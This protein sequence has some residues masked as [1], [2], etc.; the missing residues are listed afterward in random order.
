MRAM[1][2][3]PLRKAMCRSYGNALFYERVRD[4]LRCRRARRLDAA[5]ETVEQVLNIIVPRQ[6]ASMMARLCYARSAQCCARKEMRSSMPLCAKECSSAQMRYARVRRAKDDALMRAAAYDIRQAPYA[7]RRGRSFDIDRGFRYCRRARRFSATI[8]GFSRY[9]AMPIRA[10]FQ[11]MRATPC[12]AAL[13][14]LASRFAFAL[15]MPR[16]VDAAATPP[17]C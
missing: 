17:C 10:I 15:A 7:P 16:H 4:I 3:A 6:R 8:C 9:A 5:G 2:R 11:P 1:I 14:R 13:M 12:D